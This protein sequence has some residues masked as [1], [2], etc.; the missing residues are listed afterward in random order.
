MTRTRTPK[1]STAVALAAFFVTGFAGLVYEVCWIRMASLVFGSTTHALSTV[2]AVFFMGIAAGSAWF[3]ER[4]TRIE[5]PLR[6]Y[7]L[8]ELGVAAF[9]LLS[10]PAFG[11]IAPW[12]GAA[13]RAGGG[14]GPVVWLAE[15]ALVALVLLPPTF[16]MGATLP[17]FCRQFVD[18][19]SGIASRVGLLYGLNTLGAAAGC[20]VTGL[21]WIP[22]IGVQASIAI[23][24]GLSLLAGA[25]VLAVAPGALAVPGREDAAGVAH[26]AAAS[27]SPRKRG[28]QPEPRASVIAIGALFFVIGFVALGHEVLWARFATLL[29][30]N[31]IQTY[32]VTLAIVL[33]GIVFGSVLASRFYDRALP[34]ERIFGVLQALVGLT[35]LALLLAP[36]SVWMGVGDR[37]RMYVLLFMPAAVLSGALF[38]LAVRMVVDDPA[39]AGAGVGRMTALNTL[40]GIGGA[41]AAGFVLLPGLGLQRA[42]LVTTG[43]SVAGAIVTWWVLDRRARPALRWGLTLAAL[44]AWLAIPRLLPTA[45]PRD[46]LASRATLIDFVEGRESNLALLRAEGRKVLTMEGWWQGQDE[47]SHQIMAAH[48]PMLLHP[49]PRTALVIGVGA[50]Q[51]PERFTYYDIERLDCVDIEP[52]VFD[53][54]QRHFGGA[55]M[56]DPRVRLLPDDG[57]TV[58]AHRTETYDVISVE[59]GQILRPGVSAFYTE[60]FYRNARRRLNPGGVI[61]QFVPLSFMSERDF[62]GIVHTFLEVFPQSV[63]WYNRAELLLIGTNGERPAF[64]PARLELLTGEG[65]VRRDLEFALWGGPAQWQN[66]PEVFLGGFLAGPDALAR[67][68]ADGE[69]FRDDRPVLDYRAAL[70]APSDR[71]HEPILA[72]LRDHLSPIETLFPGPG[73]DSLVAAARAVRESNLRD[74]IAWSHVRE[75]TAYG[76]RGP[77]QEPERL[78]NLALEA[79]PSSERA[80]KLMGSVLLRAGRHAEAESYLLRAVELR[81]DDALAQRDLGRSLDAQG[82]RAEAFARLALAD[83]LLPTEPFTQYLLGDML[84]DAGRT[85]EA[86]SHLERAIELQPGYE[87]AERRLRILKQAR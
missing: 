28:S 75:A 61:G 53:V 57:R 70:A 64:D 12:F 82:R 45:I 4:S 50:G 18:R 73:P 78:L 62:R 72:A 43:L 51:T 2:L 16:L 36:P 6:L 67:M 42:L 56:R 81:P 68:A 3:G 31:T 22:A 35:V 84:A 14:A 59:V 47:K 39:R 65:P 79:N 5:R 44:A 24:A 58:L 29:V 11:W 26:A 77:T 25:A 27:K 10:L 87:A 49:A 7:A 41:L 83:S 80:L 15:F 60:D 76:L 20:A 23:G 63:L 46:F 48:V 69:I 54:I 71:S 33:L 30:P 66:R 21:I 17:L 32:T 74:M 9:A 85:S 34:R 52:A 40:G 8:L 55:W 1:P 86:A 37:T 19:A 13:Y 38:P